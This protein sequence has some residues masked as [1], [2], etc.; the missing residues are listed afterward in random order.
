[1]KLIFTILFTGMTVVLFGQK[2]C[3]KESGL[4]I[5][6]KVVSA[7]RYN[8]LL[9]ADS[10]DLI[11]RVFFKPKSGP[12][13]KYSAYYLL[14]D[15]LGNSMYKSEE[16]KSGQWGGQAENYFVKKMVDEDLP[17]AFKVIYE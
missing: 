15:K 2:V 9:N 7:L 14:T 1:M 6:G 11:M 12:F 4:P 16:W 17:K 5:D 10:C 8:G 3:Y 13:G